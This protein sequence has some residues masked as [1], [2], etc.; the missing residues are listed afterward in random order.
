MNPRAFTALC[1]TISRVVVVSS[2][3]CALSSAHAQSGKWKPEKNV[4]LVAPS[5]VGGGLDLTARTMQR[6]IQERKLVEAAV[7]NDATA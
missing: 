2:F 3:A 1:I 5:G 4:E 7:N 6:I